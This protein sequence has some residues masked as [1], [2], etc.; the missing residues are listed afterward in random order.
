MLANSFALKPSNLDANTLSIEVS[1]IYSLSDY[2]K[3]TQYVEKL[4]ITKKVAIKK[5]IKDRLSMNLQLNG[6][7]HQLKQTLALDRKLVPIK[8]AKPSDGFGVEHFKWNL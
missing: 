5:V 4:A 1:G 2:A 8:Q 7:V 6:S 3:M